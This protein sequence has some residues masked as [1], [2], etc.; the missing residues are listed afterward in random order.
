MA[1]CL[2]RRQV[3]HAFQAYGTRSAATGGD[4]FDD[5]LGD[6]GRGDAVLYARDGLGGNADAAEFVPDVVGGEGFAAEGIAEAVGVAQAV[7][8]PAA[9]FGL[10]LHKAG[11]EPALRRA[12]D[13]HGRSLRADGL[14][15][16][17]PAFGGAEL[18][19]GALH[20]QALEPFT[21]LD[22]QLQPGGAAQ[23]NTGVVE[24]RSG[25]DRINQLDDGVRQFG[26]GERL[27]R[28]R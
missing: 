5:R 17:Q 9:E 27:L 3:C 11:A 4:P 7:Q 28:G 19:T 18:G 13:H 24:S 12:L 15:A 14:R 16:F 6:G 8:Q 20:G 23:R 1:G 10:A 2:E 25:G 26:D 22:A 21:V